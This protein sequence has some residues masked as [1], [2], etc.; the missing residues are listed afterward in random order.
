MVSQITPASTNTK[1]TPVMI[2]IAMNRPSVGPANV[3]ALG[4]SHQCMRC[5]SF[6]SL[7]REREVR[8]FRLAARH[9]YRGGLRAVFLVP[10]LDRVCPGW[11]PADG[12]APIGAAHA[13]EGVGQHAQP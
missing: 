4:G 5:S 6:S 7:R 10:C 2:R 13:E 3:E 1:A 8:R 11:Q 12:V 9:R